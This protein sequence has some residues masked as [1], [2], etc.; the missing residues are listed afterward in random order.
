[1]SNS[2]DNLC[3]F[4]GRVGKDPEKRFTPGGQEV[5]VFSLAISERQRQ[6]DGSYADSEPTWVNFTA[7]GKT[8]ELVNRIVK[9]GQKLVA[10]SQYTSRKYTKEDGSQGYYQGFRLNSFNI[11][12]Y[13]AGS[14]NTTSPQADEG[15]YVEEGE[16][17]PF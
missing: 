13:P 8:A 4:V 16:S 3:I 14:N 12:S 15:D 10:H 11:V 2:T 6:D 7:Y 5:A 17:A 9:K 1:M